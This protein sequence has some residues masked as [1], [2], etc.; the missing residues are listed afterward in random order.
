MGFNSAFKGLNTAIT[1]AFQGLKFGTLLHLPTFEVGKDRQ[2]GPVSSST[3]LGQ[4]RGQ[5]LGGKLQDK[6][7][8]TILCTVDI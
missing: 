5:F 4:S 6:T 2:E 3:P 1:F 8:H 7:Q